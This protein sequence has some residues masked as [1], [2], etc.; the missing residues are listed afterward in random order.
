MLARLSLL[1]LSIYSILS[2]QDIPVEMEILS[3]SP[4][5]FLI[6]NFL[7]DAECDRIIELAKPDLRR[8]TVV[9]DSKVSGKIDESR[10]SQGMFF[11]GPAQDPM[12]RAIEE[13][14]AKVT[15]IPKENGEAIQVLNYQV[16]QEYRPHYD[17]FDPATIGGMANYQRGG[18]RVATLIMYLHTTQ[19]GGETVFPKANLKIAPKKG[20]AVLFYNCTLD[21]KEDP[22]SLHGGA[23]VIQGEKWIATKWMRTGKFK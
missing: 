8:S 19:T 13:R 15:L 9:D 23:P 16:N 5:V 14:I 22:M 6:H 7:S 21:G 20:N 10:T 4:R 11:T 18:Q 1:C 3:W 17:Y 12:L 2:A